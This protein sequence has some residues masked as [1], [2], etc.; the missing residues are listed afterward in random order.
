MWPSFDKLR[1]EG[2]NEVDGA[3]DRAIAGGLMLLKAGASSQHH[4]DRSRS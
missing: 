1:T 4:E 2:V 3:I